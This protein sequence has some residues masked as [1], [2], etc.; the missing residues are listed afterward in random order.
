M[1]SMEAQVGLTDSMWGDEHR[2]GF[3]SAST[4]ELLHIS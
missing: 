2:H 1:F 4:Q 3:K